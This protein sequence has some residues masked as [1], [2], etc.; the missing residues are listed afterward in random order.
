MITYFI[1]SFYIRISREW[2]F[3]HCTFSTVTFC[4]DGNGNGKWEMKG[5]GKV[6]R[7]SAHKYLI[8]YFTYNFMTVECI[9]AVVF[10]FALVLVSCAYIITFCCHT[11]VIS[12]LNVLLWSLLF[13][14][15]LYLYPLSILLN[16]TYNFQWLCT[17]YYIR[18]MLL[19]WFSPN[20]QCT[21]CIVHTC[22]YEENWSST[23]NF[24]VPYSKLQLEDSSTRV[25]QDTKTSNMQKT[26]KQNQ[27][28]RE[29]KTEDRKCGG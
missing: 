14:S 16:A 10:V 18:I 12:W 19:H 27:R 20:V 22:R 2:H 3:V 25:K 6:S 24:Q 15:S 11:K 23:F 26:P 13:S 21:L 28:R 5:K 7:R 4:V 8:I 9:I 29:N 1:F 17:L